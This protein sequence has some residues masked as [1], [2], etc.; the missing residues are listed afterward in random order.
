MTEQPE[1]NELGRFPK[2]LALSLVLAG[3]VG[4]WLSH[5]VSPSAYNGYF[6]EAW[7][8]SSFIIEGY[9]RPPLDETEYLSFVEHPQ[10][11]QRPGYV[12]MSYHS[13]K[14]DHS[15]HLLF[16][17]WRKRN[18]FTTRFDKQFGFDRVLVPIRFIDRETTNKPEKFA[19]L[20]RQFPSG[21]E[22]HSKRSY[23]LGGALHRIWQSNKACH[24]KQNTAW[25]EGKIRHSGI[26]RCIDLTFSDGRT[27][28][29]IR[30]TVDEPGG[31]F[32]R[33]SNAEPSIDAP[34]SD[35]L[36]QP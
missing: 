12:V 1:H 16:E 11:D 25:I 7:V 32:R 2:K 20:S 17:V 29:E 33:S 10:I 24:T 3:F 23:G 5:S 28:V 18:V 14:L 6:K 9:T 35:G 34:G 21:C 22:L 30:R 36:K 31:C 19:E 15:I 26:V 4:Y 8:T 13:E 27:K